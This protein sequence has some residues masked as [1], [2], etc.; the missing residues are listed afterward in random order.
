MTSWMVDHLRP[1]VPM[2]FTAFHPDFKMTNRPPTRA[3]TLSRAP[4]IALANGVRYAYTGNV[5]DSVGGSTCCHGSSIT[6][7]ERDGYALGQYR[8]SDDGPCQNCGAPCPGI[9]QEPV[10][11]W[12]ARRRPV[13]IS[14]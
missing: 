12:G 4:R 5:H 1:D 10:G 11:T 6:L 13:A 14:D 9:Y 3:E 7:I 8:L 2:H